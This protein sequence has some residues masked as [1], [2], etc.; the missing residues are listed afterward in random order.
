MKTRITYHVSR[1]KKKMQGQALIPVVLLMFAAL[2]IGLAAMVISR[3]LIWDYL[4]VGGGLRALNAAESAMENGYMRLLRDIGY[5]GESLVID[6]CD[7]TV[8]VTGDDV[9]KVVSSECSYG[10]VIKRMQTAVNYDMGIMEVS[11]EGEI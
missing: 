2:N 9:N 7:C 5:T 6:D 10:R 11:G 3:G 1:I 8:T 4:T